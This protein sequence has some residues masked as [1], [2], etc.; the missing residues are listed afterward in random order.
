MLA[1]QE[2]EGRLHWAA[3]A[4]EQ[5]AAQSQH[6][7]PPRRQHGAKTGGRM[8]I[9]PALCAFSALLPPPAGMQQG[10]P[11]QA[12]LVAGCERDVQRLAGRAL[13]FLGKVCLP[14][15]AECMN[16]CAFYSCLSGSTYVGC[17]CTIASSSS[18]VVLPGCKCSLQIRVCI[19]HA[20]YVTIAARTKLPVHCGVTDPALDCVAE[21]I[22]STG[23][24]QVVGEDVVPVDDPG[25]HSF[26][27]AALLAPASLGVPSSED[28]A[29]CALVS[30]AKVPCLRCYLC[31]PLYKCETCCCCFALS[32][33]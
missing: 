13:A 1:L 25:L 7:V 30:Q 8:H 23:T 2:L 33:F 12:S 16:Y 11:K 14:R 19:E 31:C 29:A 24:M 3:W 20:A 17:A 22:L 5:G 18:L 27:L 15:G 28:E 9:V 4:L 21:H 10:K 32:L 26:L 6:L